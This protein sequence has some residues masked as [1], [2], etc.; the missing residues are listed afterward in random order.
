MA[1]EDD[2]L[3][4]RQWHLGAIDVFPVWRDY[5]G[6][7]VRV[8]VA[9]TG[10]QRRHPDLDANY[11]RRLE[12]DY[13]FGE[14]GGGPV[15]PDDDHGT[16][17]AGLI[18]AEGGNGIGGAGVAFGASITS[19]QLVPSDAGVEAQMFDDAHPF[20]VLNN[21]WGYG[22][23]FD[24]APFFDDFLDDPVFQEV[25]VA[26]EGL[27]RDGRDGLGTVV[28]FAAGNER[29]VDGNVNYH[30]LANS[31]FT[32][33]VAASD[34]DGDVTDYSNPGAALLVTAPGGKGDIVTT[35]RT[36][37]DGYQRGDYTFD[38]S[39][40]SASAPI[41]SG[42]VALMLEA[43]PALGYRDVQEILAYSARQTGGDA[44]WRFNGADHWNGGGLHVSHDY[45]FGL[46]DAHAAVRL[47][48]TWRS[49]AVYADEASRTN[50]ERFGAS[51]ALPD[52]GE[53]TVSLTMP[54]LEIDQVEVVVDLEHSFLHDLEMRLTSPD[55]TRSLLLDHAD[56]PGGSAEGAW[57]FSSTRHWGE[58]TAGDW[59]LTIADPVRGGE[60]VLKSWQLTLYGDPL[61]ADD[62]YVFTDEYAELAGGARSTLRDAGGL[63]IV[64][65]AA[66]SGDLVLDLSPGSQSRIAGATLTIGRGTTIEQAIGG[67]GDDL[68]IGN[69]SPNLLLG[70]R[71]DDTLAGGGGD[72]SL[73]GGPGADR[74]L[75]G[76]GRD[77][78]DGEA[79]RDLALG[80]RGAD[81]LVGGPAADELRGGRGHDQLFGASGDDLLVGGDGN[82]DLLG[83]RGLDT[84]IG[85]AGRD[86]FR[87]TDLDQ[88]GDRIA[89]FALGPDGDRLVIGELL[90]GYV[91]G[92][93]AV[94]DFVG[95]RA[96]GN[97][98]EVEVDRDGQGA[99]PVRLASLEGISA[100]SLDNLIADGNLVLTVATT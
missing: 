68:L 17:V 37:G 63:D 13:R 95:L 100:A 32:I 27:A 15:F 36:G 82:D 78:L 8:G 5:S 45:G 56:F 26:L 53:V 16:A 69:G 99:N 21:S 59:Q 74:L 12:F 92:S 91:E 93:S 71:G 19:L 94:A 2:P 11:D 67:D 39:G 76:R 60:G 79:G 10:V 49:A 62:T 85:G 88:R 57:L 7:G 97:A 24:A 87:Y 61:E 80:R 41:V 6:A 66:L 58:S 34:R 18:A 35:D 31:R 43:N 48:E 86:D 98:V 52:R 89:D 72:D 65:A 3:V 54:A 30:N 23:V 55:G 29:A 4:G 84:L 25:A 90:E 96:T 73:V 75:G 42:V 64:N 9:D 38:F 70:Q 44:G 1:A 14:P 46:V 50:G 81:L 20:D 22:T 40:T 51:L 28:V 77:G 33:A 83:G 47:A